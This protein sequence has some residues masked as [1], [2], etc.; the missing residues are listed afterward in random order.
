[1]EIRMG[2]VVNFMRE[3]CVTV[4]VQRCIRFLCL[5]G[6]T[7]EKLRYSIDL[8]P[9]RHDLPLVLVFSNMPCVLP[10]VSA[11]ARSATSPIKC[12]KA[13]GVH[14]ADPAAKEGDCRETDTLKSRHNVDSRVP[15][16]WLAEQSKVKR[17]SVWWPEHARCVCVQA[18]SP[19]AI[20]GPHLFLLLRSQLCSV[21][22]PIRPRRLS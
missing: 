20:S 3:Y 15:R 5:L 13:D 1:M 2:F 18:G 8:E 9:E 19:L 17:F 21:A 14:Q 4:L 11:G 22:R 12:S 16:A 7:H 6:M 10:D